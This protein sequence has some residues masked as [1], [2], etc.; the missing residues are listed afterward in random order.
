MKITKRK[1]GGMDGGTGV[2]HFQ[3]V[4]IVAVSAQLVYIPVSLLS[5]ECVHP[6]S[7]TWILCNSHCPRSVGYDVTRQ[8]LF[9]S[10]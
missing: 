1:G 7:F 8:R 3:W 6:H 5:T 9:F 2:S 4:H 10:S